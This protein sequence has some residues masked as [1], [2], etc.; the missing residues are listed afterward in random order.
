MMLPEGAKLR[1]HRHSE[2]IGDAKL[3]PEGEELSGETDPRAVSQP[4]R[5]ISLVAA[6]GRLFPSSLPCTFAR[7]V[8]PRCYPTFSSAPLSHRATQQGRLRRQHPAALQRRNLQRAVCHLGEAATLWRHW[9]AHDGLT[10]FKE[11]GGGGGHGVGL[12]S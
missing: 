8:R 5:A 3:R 2:A 12:L 11:A 6:L 1:E 7:S 4:W 10:A 9:R